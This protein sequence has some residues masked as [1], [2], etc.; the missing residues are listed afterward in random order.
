MKKKM[1]AVGL[2]TWKLKGDEC[3][4]VVRDALDLGY[5]H[6]DTAHV[7]ENHEAVKK[8]IE[9]YNREE[10]F[11]TS[12]IAVELINAKSVLGSVK[13]RCESALEEL[14]TDYLDLYLIHA[15]DRNYPLLEIFAAMQSLVRDGKV[16]SIG[17]S[18]FTIHHLE[19]F[20][21]EGLRPSVNQVEFHPYLYQKELWQF[22]QSEGIQLVS[23]RSFGK[24]ALLDEPIFKEIG[25]RHKK[26]AAQVILRWL[27]QKEIPSIPKAS[28]K[29]R[30]KENISIFDFALDPKEM[31]DLDGLNQNKRFC[32]A[33][34]TEFNY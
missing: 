24:G 31:E 23:Y 9:G 8:G 3:V 29:E 30:L 12:K 20:T 11:L 10:L 25:K 16:C 22:C 27:Y 34:D 28:S 4:R 14:G 13:K 21:R 18:N 17:V 32:K 15:P 1:P 7:Y 26:S 33:E 6:I 5:R 2:G 19:D